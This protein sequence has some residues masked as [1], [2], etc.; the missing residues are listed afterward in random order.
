[1][2]VPSLSKTGQGGSYLVRWSVWFIALNLIDALQTAMVVNRFGL[3]AEFNPLMQWLL[4]HYSYLGLYV[5]KCCVV[6]LVIILAFSWSQRVLHL[7]TC[8]MAAIVAINFWTLMQ[9]GM[10]W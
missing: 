1:M 3:A 6:S 7:A 2:D 9:R 4:D 8:G 10:L 5:A